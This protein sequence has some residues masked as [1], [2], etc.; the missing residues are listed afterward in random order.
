ME[1]KLIELLKTFEVP[2][3]RQGSLSEDEAYPETF[4]TFWE[5]PEYEHSAYDNETLNVEYEFDVNV[6]ST[7]PSTTYQ[8]LRNARKLLK[9]NGFSFSDR[10][11]DVAS[12]EITH[13][14]RGITVTYLNYEK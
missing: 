14:G 13:T 4:F 7:D 8:L 1:D 12:D 10:G 11:H 2:V 6:Y 3:L 9:S 5:A